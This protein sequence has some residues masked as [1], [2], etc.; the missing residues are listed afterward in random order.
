[1]TRA[2]R[3]ASKCGSAFR[4]R[5]IGAL[6]AQALALVAALSPA[7]ALDFPARTGRV[8]DE[9]GILGARRDLADALAALEEKTTDQLVV[10]TVTSLRGQSIEQYANAL[11]RHWKLGQKDKN[12]GV[13]LIVAPNERK[14]RIEVGYGLEGVLTD[15]L[16]KTI[17]EQTI[18]PRF[19]SNDMPGG[20]SEGV[21][22][23]IRTLTA[24]PAEAKRRAEAAAEPSWLE[25]AGSFLGWAFVVL[26]LMAMGGFIAFVAGALIGAVLLNIGIALGL[27][28]KRKHRDERWKWLDRWDFNNATGSSS[29]SSSSSSDG[30]S[31]G[32]GS[33]GGGGASGS[34]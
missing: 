3:F 22:E 20:V 12:N 30:F 7:A 11:F 23:I 33:S 10:A 32:G 18:L 19:R 27:L 6:A 8:V 16:S 17:I 13:L 4:A 28:P 1:M 14:V 25:A 34:W 24:D 26:I 9:A 15:A 2:A 5:L 29:S 21:D 31:G